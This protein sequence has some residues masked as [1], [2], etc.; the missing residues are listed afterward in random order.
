MIT[1]PSKNYNPAKKIDV[2]EANGPSSYTTGGFT[3]YSKMMKVEHAVVNAGNGYL[4]EVVSVSGSAIKIK[5]YQFNYPA[6]AAGPAVEVPA[7][8]DLSSVKFT[9]IAIG[10]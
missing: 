7:G 5:V 4:A 1:I 6:T 2:I 10:Q 9:V 3:V 8:T